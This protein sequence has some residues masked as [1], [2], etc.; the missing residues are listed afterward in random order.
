MNEV[1]NVNC[2]LKSHTRH[3]HVMQFKLKLL[4]GTT[5]FISIGS[6]Q[7]S[8]I[9]KHCIFPLPGKQETNMKQKL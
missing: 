2:K 6:Y 3:R 4:F 1:S 5:P 7:V 9:G 8:M